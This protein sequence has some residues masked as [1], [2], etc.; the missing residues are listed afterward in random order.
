MRALYFYLVVVYFSFWCW[1]FLQSKV[2][3]ILTGFRRL[4][5]SLIFNRVRSQLRS[6]LNHFF[7]ARVNIVFLRNCVFRS[8]MFIYYM[9]C[10]H[11]HAHRLYRTTWIKG[12]II[13]SSPFAAL[14]VVVLIF[15]LIFHLS[16]WLFIVPSY[17]RGFWIHSVMHWYSIFFQIFFLV[18]KYET[19]V[20]RFPAFQSNKIHAWRNAEAMI[21]TMPV[22]LVIVS[23]TCGPHWLRAT[24]NIAHAVLGQ[25]QPA[26]NL[27]CSRMLPR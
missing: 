20:L 5:E 2:V 3:T 7:H 21:S 9:N 25:E 6:L 18:H 1:S 27:R 13:L 26:T 11:K 4:I 12:G 16:L 17:L 14:L 23:L 8:I 19:L 22:R 15:F 10:I 24:E